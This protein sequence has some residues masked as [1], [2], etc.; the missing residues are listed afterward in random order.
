MKILII[1][2]ACIFL[3]YPIFFLKAGIVIDDEYICKTN[4]CGISKEK[5]SYS[6]V[7]TFEISIKHG[8]EYDITFNSKNKINL[9]SHEM[10][11]FNYFRNEK[12]LQIFDELLEKHGERIVYKSI[13]STPQNIK[14]FFK[15]NEYYNYFNQIFNSKTGDRNDAG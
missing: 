13:Y 8:V 15:K 10:I 7:S 6:D 14:N 4:I 5:Y 2:L 1:I 12:N 9:Y 3:V 11:L